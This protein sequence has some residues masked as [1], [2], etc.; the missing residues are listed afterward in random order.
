VGGPLER[1]DRGGAKPDVLR[2]GDT[3]IY[4]VEGV[5]ATQV[6]EQRDVASVEV[7]ART[8]RVMSTRRSRTEY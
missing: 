5:I 6:Y 8:K 4:G 3:N 2:V 7:D 1:S